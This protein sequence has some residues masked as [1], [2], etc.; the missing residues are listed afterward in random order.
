MHILKKVLIMIEFKICNLDIKAEIKFLIR[1][2]INPR[3]ESTAM[4]PPSTAING[5]KMCEIM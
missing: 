2:L 1:S 4:Y 5:C 3:L